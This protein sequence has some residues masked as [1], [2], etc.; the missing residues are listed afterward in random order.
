M[1][2][3][4]DRNEMTLM[5]DRIVVI[6][7]YGQ[8]G[9]TICALLGELYPGKVYAAGRN[10]ERAERYCRTTGGSVRPMKFDVREPADADFWRTTR[11]VVMCLDQTDPAF[12]RACLENGTHYTDISA[13]YTFLSKVEALH[14]TAKA[15]RATAVINVGLAPGLTNLMAS[16]AAKRMDRTARLDIGLL[17]GLGDQHGKSGIEWMI[18][19]LCNDFDVE[20]DGHKKRIPGFS[21]GRKIDFGDGLGMWTAYRFNFSDQHSLKKTMNIPLVSTRLCLDSR[22]LNT[23]L[24]L[25]KATRLLNALRIR[26]IRDLAVRLFG[27]IRIGKDTAAVKIDAWGMRGSDDI[28]IE[29]FMRGRRESVFTG[30]VAAFAADRL[31]REEYASGVYHIEQLFELED[32]LQWSN[33]AFRIETRI[34]GKSHAVL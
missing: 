34:N 21:D 20:T 29:C 26:R 12:V 28:H 33:R 3:T 8:S 4:I 23:L 15:H 7:G 16:Y 10:P 1:S 18:D 14:D 11:L 25:F 31:Y 22:I 13:D 19:N 9:Q 27:G 5:K 2:G 30:T 24:A 6:G 17:L 32:L